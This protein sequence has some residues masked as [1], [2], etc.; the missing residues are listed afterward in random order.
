MKTQKTIT[1]NFRAKAE[2]ADLENLGWDF[3]YIYDEVAE[4]QK[5]TTEQAEE[6][7]KENYCVEITVN[8]AGK[9]GYSM[10]QQPH[11]G[12]ESFGQGDTGDDKKTIEDLNLLLAEGKL[13][14]IE[15]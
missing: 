1:T 10:Q 15:K 14:D 5:L 9:T 8:E 2:I 4:A 6:W 3:S 13:W 7:E 12:N 11:Y